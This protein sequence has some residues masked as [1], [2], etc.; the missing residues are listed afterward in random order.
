MANHLALLAFAT[1]TVLPGRAFALEDSYLP[2]DKI[3][4][5]VEATDQPQRLGALWG[6]RARGR[7]ARC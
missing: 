7:P 5:A 6:E 4:Y 2:A 1:L 3:P